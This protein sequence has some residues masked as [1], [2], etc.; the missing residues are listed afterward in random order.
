M[1]TDEMLVLDSCGST[2]QQQS[3]LVGIT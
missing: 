1:I 2:T 3:D